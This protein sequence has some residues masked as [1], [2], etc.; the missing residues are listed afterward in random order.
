MDFTYTYTQEQ[1][2]FREEV[3]TWLEKNIPENMKD[4]IDP[5]DFT[6]EQY[7]YWQEKHRELAAKGWLFPTYP[8]QYGG[9]GLSS[10]HEAILQ[11]EF[12]RARVNTRTPSSNNILGSLSV[13]CT[14]EQ[15]QKFL[16]PLLKAEKAS[17][18]KFTEPKSGSD[19][20][21]YQTKAVR[22]GDDW[23][24]T[25][26]NVFVSRRG[27]KPDYLWGPAVTD[28]EAPRHRNLGF[29][30]VPCPSPGLEIKPLNLIQGKDQHFVYLDNVRVPGD[31][32]IGGDHQGWQVANTVLEEEHGG[33]GR[34]YPED[35][36]TENLVSYMREHRQKGENPGGDPVLQQA[37][38]EG[39]IA[40]KIDRLFKLR[41]H[42]M[43]GNRVEMSWEGPSGFHYQR[44]YGFRNVARV[45]DVMGM[46][47]LLGTKDSL[48]PHGGAQEVNQRTS[49][50][51]QHGAGS[52]NITKIVLA[53]RIGISR[54][55]ERAAPTRMT[56]G[57]HSG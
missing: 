35:S 20:A 45:R 51:H 1:E 32:L 5:D 28:P 52:F 56:A 23:I 10:G 55:K 41:T 14:E 48:A 46:Y 47:A 38:L 44:L 54:T 6:E 26:S 8:K 57:S 18:Q 39:Y 15:K 11:E 31:H 24:I 36:V 19:L 13:W 29:F 27:Y 2:R 9:G 33:A 22:D 12:E 34:A 42:W 16:V 37:A 30:M 3:R 25:G 40:A 50:I 21:S 17:W 4:P 49:F 7:L 43:Y 53:R